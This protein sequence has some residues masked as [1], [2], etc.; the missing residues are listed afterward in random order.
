MA[1]VVVHRTRVPIEPEDGLGDFGGFNVFGGIKQLFTRPGRA[2]S[3]IIRTLPRTLVAG[4]VGA[5]LG[6]PTTEGFGANTLG[7]SLGGALTGAGLSAYSAAGVKTAYKPTIG[8]QIGQGL[9]YGI[10]GGTLFNVGKGIAAGI[11]AAK[12]PTGDFTTSP[13]AIVGA[14]EVGLATTKQAFSS[15]LVGTGITTLWGL[16]Y[17]PQALAGAGL[18]TLPALAGGGKKPP[19]PGDTGFMQDASIPSGP[20]NPPTALP[21]PNNVPP[22]APSG[23]PRE[24]QAVQAAYQKAY[25]QRAEYVQQ[26]VAQGQL[27][28][29]QAQQQMA[30][31]AQNLQ[32]YY[33]PRLAAAQ[34]AAAQTAQQTATDFGLQSTSPSTF[35]GGSPYSSPLPDTINPSDPPPLLPTATVKEGIASSPILWV[36]LAAVGATVFAFSSQPKRV[37]HFPRRHFADA[38]NRSSRAI[39]SVIRGKHV[40]R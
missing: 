30:Q 28:P 11:E 18:L 1:F 12:L 26:A 24:V 16:K 2:L 36:G 17:G 9:L 4:G 33:G 27:T 15:S 34:A 25:T 7:L 22:G 35:A 40:R 20:A 37:M 32:D 31:Y 3:N 10:A 21:P 19:Q 13:K 5:V 39:G 38:R 6:A 8:K 23:V 29:D 14:A